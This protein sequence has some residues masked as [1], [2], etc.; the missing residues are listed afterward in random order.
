M[1]ALFKVEEK[2]PISWFYRKYP[3]KDMKVGDSFVVSPE[4]VFSVRS[5]SCEY[6]KRYGWKFSTRR[7]SRTEYRCWRIA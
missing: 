1:P 7:V 5:T 4:N 6:G 2:I 3:F